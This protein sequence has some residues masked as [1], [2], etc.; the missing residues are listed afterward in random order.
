MME[1]RPIGDTGTS[2]GLYSI[3]SAMFGPWVMP[4]DVCVAILILLKSIR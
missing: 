1:Y 4:K 2:V 3:G